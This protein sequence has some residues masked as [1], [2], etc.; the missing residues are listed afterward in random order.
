MWQSI[1]KMHFANIGNYTIYIIKVKNKS[2]KNQMVIFIMAF[3]R[4]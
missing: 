1:L 4:A 3:F 2:F